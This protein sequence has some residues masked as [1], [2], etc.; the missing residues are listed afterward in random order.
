MA[1]SVLDR[2]SNMGKGGGESIQKEIWYHEAE[3]KGKRGPNG[4]HLLLN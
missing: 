2:R 4:M 3:Y 1:E